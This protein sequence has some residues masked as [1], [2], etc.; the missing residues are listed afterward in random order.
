[1]IRS[2]LKKLLSEFICVGTYFVEIGRL[3]RNA[4]PTPTLNVN[5]ANSDATGTSC[6]CWCWEGSAITTNY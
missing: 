5:F 4:V 1:M 3:N 2:L 6:K